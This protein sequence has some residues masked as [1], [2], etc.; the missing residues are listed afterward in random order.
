[1]ANTFTT[2]EFLARTLAKEGNVEEAG[3]YADIWRRLA[4]YSGSA[5]VFWGYILS[6]DLHH[7]DRRHDD[8]ATG[9]IVGM[10]DGLDGHIAHY[11]D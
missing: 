8:R 7:P 10:W 3:K 5:A 2:Y 4:R 6:E 9:L 11:A 1:M